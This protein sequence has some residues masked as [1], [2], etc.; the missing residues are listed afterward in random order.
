M[1]VW[2]YGPNFLKGGGTWPAIWMLG[3]NFSEV[4]WPASGEIDIMEHKGNEPNVI[5]GTLHYPGRS[6]GNADG[7]YHWNFQRK[8]RIPHLYYGMV[9]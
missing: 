1:A 8:F 4:G 7:G 3:S 2:K 9:S 5:H 6:G